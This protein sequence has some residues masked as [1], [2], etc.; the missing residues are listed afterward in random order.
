MDSAQPLQILRDNKNILRYRYGKAH[1]SASVSYSGHMQTE[2]FQK[3]LSNGMRLSQL[4]D[5]QSKPLTSGG[6]KVDNE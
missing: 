1:L 4:L 3:Q 2:A 6:G 5:G